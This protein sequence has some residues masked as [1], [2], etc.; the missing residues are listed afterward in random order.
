MLGEVLL[1]RRLIK[2]NTALWIGAGIFHISFWL[3][4][5]RH[6]RYFF[7][8]VPEWILSMQKVGYYAGLV[9]PFALLFLLSRRLWSEREIY[10]SVFTDYF[11]LF[12][13]LLISGTGIW[14]STYGRIFLIDVKAY[15]L[16][17]YS[18]SFQAPPKHPLFI[19]HLMAVFTFLLYFPWSKLL[20]APGVFFSPAL[21]QRHNIEKKRHINP[22]DYPVEAE[23][24]YT[25]EDIKARKKDGASSAD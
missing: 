8:P 16:G 22:W 2:S 23:P 12:L 21:F 1:F 17:L 19:T 3:V 10:I 5:I 11:T 9:M 6:L 7:Y 14:M 20:H 15:L 13:L 18:F 24:F 25:L 4:I